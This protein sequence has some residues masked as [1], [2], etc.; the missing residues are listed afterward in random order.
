M[1]AI[2]D[3]YI[4]K[5]TYWVIVVIHIFSI[6]CL[7]IHKKKSLLYT[8][9]PTLSFN[10]PIQN[11]FWHFWKIKLFCPIEIFCLSSSERKRFSLF[12]FYGPSRLFH[13]FW[14]Q[15]IVRWGENGRSPRKTTWPPASRT[16]LVQHVTW[17]RLEPTAVR[18]RAMISGLNHSAKGKE[19]PTYLPNENIQGRGTSN[20]TFLRMDAVVFFSRCPQIRWPSTESLLTQEHL[21]A[22]SVAT[23]N[24]A[25]SRQAAQVQKILNFRTPE[26]LL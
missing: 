1:I 2:L 6:A 21:W 20:K 4:S 5:G 17:A 13:S 23:N 9:L 18:W 15:S 7:I 26:N 24:T 10:Q 12:G 3:Y 16:W 8:Y 25:Q 11:L 14:A 22:P 19:F